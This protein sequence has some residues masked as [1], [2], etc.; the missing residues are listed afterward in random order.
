MIGVREDWFA[1]SVWYFDVPQAAALGEQLLHLVRAEHAR[2]PAGLAG[3]CAGPGWHSR[4]DLH[5]REGFGPLETLVCENA[6]EV[7]RFE[8][9]DLERVTPV[10]TAAWALVHGRDAALPAHHHPG[11]VLGGLYTVSAPEGRGGLLFVD[12]RERAGRMVIHP[13]WLPYA[14]GPNR[15]D[16]E[17]ISIGFAVGVR[18][19]AG[20]GG[21]PSCSVSAG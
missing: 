3:R 13:G 8:R 6:T 15:S 20:A 11:S 21:A 18:A 12:P 14:V 2:D 4:E 19:R 16:G 10:V 7:A 5:R 17:C 1:T 9:W